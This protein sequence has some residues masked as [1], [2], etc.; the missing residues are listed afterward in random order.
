[1]HL[2]HE[3]M[4]ESQCDFRKVV[5]TSD[6]MF[7]ARQLQEMCQDQNRYLFT[8]LDDLT[9][10]F[11]KIC[12]KGLGKI[13]GKY[14][15]PEKFIAIVKLFHEGMLASVLDEGKSS[16]TTQVT[17]GVKQGC[18][19]P[20]TLFS[21]VFSAMLKTASHDDTDTMAIHPLPH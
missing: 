12:R 5:G 14:G 2:K 3:L 13:M 19:L 16:E 6:M 7:T 21:R 9:K 10:A 8:A 17:N 20:P 1:M 11:E 4:P 18:M 15:I